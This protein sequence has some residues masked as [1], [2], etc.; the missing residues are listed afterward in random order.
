MRTN[1]K[2]INI[3]KCDHCAIM[4]KKLLN[5]RDKAT[6]VAEN[7]SINLK[8]AKCTPNCVFIEFSNKK[9]LQWHLKLEEKS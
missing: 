5:C 2:A 9:N 7:E 6:A 8:S 4:N 1:F 3:N